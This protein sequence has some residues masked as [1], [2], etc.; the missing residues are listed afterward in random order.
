MSDSS[1]ADTTELILH[2]IV[3]HLRRVHR[4]VDALR[5]EVQ[6]VR[7]QIS[8]LVDAQTALLD[9]VRDHGITVSEYP[10]KADRGDRE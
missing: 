5:V 1:S 3:D 10:T 4:E 2:N 6:S 9:L 7:E 8:Q